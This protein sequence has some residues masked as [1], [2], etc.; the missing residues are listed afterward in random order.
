MNFHQTDYEKF[1]GMVR[2]IKEST[3]WNQIS[4]VIIEDIRPSFDCYYELP[5]KIT[6]EEYLGG[7]K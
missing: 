6:K 1:L 2:Y 3:N 5:I 7:G 4:M